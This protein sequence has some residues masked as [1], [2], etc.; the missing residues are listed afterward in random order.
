MIETCPEIEKVFVDITP[1]GY[2]KES[3]SGLLL[4]ERFLGKKTPVGLDLFSGC[5]GFSLGME[6]GG[7]DVVCAI[8]WSIDAAITYLWNLGRLDGCKVTYTD[9]S[10][11]KKLFREFENYEKKRKGGLAREIQ[12]GD[13][14]WIGA[15]YRLAEGERDMG[16]RAF[17][18][19]DICKVKGEELLEFVGVEKFDVIFGGPPCQGLSI[20][21]KNACLEDPRNALIYEFM[22]MV[23][24]LR[25]SAWIMENVPRI[26]TMGKGAIYKA[27][28]A[29]ACPLGYTVVANVLN[30]VDYG[31]PQNRKRA[32]IVGTLD[33][34]TYQYPMPTTWPMGST[35]D[36]KEWNMKERAREDR[37][38]GESGQLDM[39]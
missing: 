16:C 8:E 1:R 23:E 38:A 39:F 5:G 12:P 2:L 33:G 25:P 3:D 21:N 10:F 29:K 11:R 4:P 24:E 37:G 32:I 35:P 28:K 26:L 19:G 13:H 20:A 15:G 31:V 27:I 6:W 7:I 14:G 30:A 9:E 34:N 36:G 17:V 22:R 18:L